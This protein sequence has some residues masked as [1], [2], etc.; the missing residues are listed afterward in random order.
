MTRR[1]RKGSLIIQHEWEKAR[2]EA[3]AAAFEK[4]FREGAEAHQR[5]L[6]TFGPYIDAKARRDAEGDQ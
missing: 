6:E 1:T 4:M 5:F 2:A 3:Y